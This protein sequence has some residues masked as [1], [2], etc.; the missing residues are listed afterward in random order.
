VILHSAAANARAE[1]H[2]TAPAY[3]RPMR[4]AAAVV[5]AVLVVLCGCGDDP[6][7][8]VDRGKPL[9]EPSLAQI[10]PPALA[11][12]SCP[13]G[14]DGF[15]C[16]T[17]E[18]PLRHARPE[19]PAITLAVARRK[20]DAAP[21]GVL[22]AL[23][24]GPGQPARFFG[25]RIADRL[26]DA[27]DGYQ[28]VAL[29]QR[30]TGDGAIRCPGLQ[31]TTG[32]SD[33]LAPPATAVR[34][35]ARRIGGPDRLAAYATAE[36][37]EDLEALRQA[38]GADKLTLLGVSYGTFVAERYALAHP[39]RVRGL[40]LD[41]VVP[42]EGVE[43]LQ[44]VPL[45][46][47]ARVLRAVCAKPCPSDPAADLRAVATKNASLAV[48]LYDAITAVT[49]GRPRIAGVPAL[50]RRARAGD[51]G[52]LRRFVGEVVA[53]ERGV[54]AELFSAGLHAATLC[55]DSPAPWGAPS[56]PL[57]DRAG[58]LRRAH[59]RTGPWPPR[60]ALEQGLV[61]TCLP[62]P[63]L[64]PPRAPSRGKIDAPALLLNGDRDLSTPL[65]WAR[66]QARTM[67]RAR[68]H[69]LPGAGHSIISRDRANRARPLARRFLAGL[70]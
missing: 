28:V 8:T 25:P 67:P 39:D 14:L 55:A 53:E 15:E 3:A 22:V 56:T 19:G 6:T 70:R 30:G 61:R 57:A 58:A 32:T 33:I 26:G 12:A 68:L 51:A 17:L 37:V 35:C 62:W 36:T 34:A 63:A 1:R 38:L 13:S 42:Q 9:A 54:P 69:L 27:L 10:P 11:G 23:S 49:I 4:P 18:V 44:Q 31:G 2:R 65:E 66:A 50:L 46:A 59:P 40:I 48:P 16:S 7:A 60:V 24:G 45:Q 43:L 5:L 20:V 29:D 41:S 64:T 47:T 52:P 21:K